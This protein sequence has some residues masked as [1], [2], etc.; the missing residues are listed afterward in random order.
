MAG[1]ILAALDKSSSRKGLVLALYAASVAYFLGIILLPTTIGVLTKLGSAQ[2]VFADPALFD[3]AISAIKSSFGLAFLVSSLDLIAGIP[4]AWLIAR[5]KSSLI[6]VLDWLVDLPLIVPTVTLGYSAL[7]FWSSDNPFGFLGMQPLSP[8]W[9]LVLLL[10]F[11]FSYPVVVRVMVSKIMELDQMYEIAGRTLGATP[12]TAAR[13]ISIQLLSSGIVASFLLAFSRSL[14]ETG[15]TI[16]VAGIFENGPVFIRRAKEA[17]MDGPMVFTSLALILLSLLVYYLVRYLGVRVRIPFIRAWPDIEKKLSGKE[18]TTVRDVLTVLIFVF[19]I[20][21]PT[22]FLSLKYAPSLFGSQVLSQFLSSTG[23]WSSF[24]A[25]LILSYS[26]GLVVGV[27]NTVFS[28]P[29]AIIIARRRFGKLPAT[30]L[31]GLTAVPLIIPSVALGAS[32]GLF[33]GGLRTLPEFLLIVF[34]HLSITY[35][36]LVATMVSA[37]EDIPPYFEESARTLGAN[38]FT[39]FRTV[40]LPMAK[41]SLI[42]GIMLTFTRSVDETGATLA[43]VSQL[44]TV[45]VLLVDWIR[46]A[47]PGSDLAAG[48]GTL[49]LLLISFFILL[50]LR[51]LTRPGERF[52]KS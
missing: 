21:S 6:G 35:P 47:F 17:G 49:L 24:W 50:M 44:K 23:I 10:H 3:R 12:L 11:C 20:M 26:I 1:G 7:L 28:I 41:Y 42:S 22:I 15:A 2:Q 51:L 14:S 16:V 8:G 52:A 27:I 31:D 40:T 29:M 30:I 38:A 5:R 39:V 13:S 18:T 4:L 19:F 33:W 32:M 34:A 9:V 43:V 36:Y 37:F 48:F 45:P 46:S 25:S